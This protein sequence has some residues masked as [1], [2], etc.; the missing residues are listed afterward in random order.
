MLRFLVAAFLFA[1][2]AYAD[3][4][5]F[6]AVPLEAELGAKI[7]RAAEASLKDFP[8]LTADNLALSVI[9]VTKPDALVRADYHGDAPFYPASVIKLFFMVEAYREFATGSGEDVK[10]LKTLQSYKEKN[11]RIPQ[12]KLTPEI[13]RA[14]REMIQVSDNDAAAF[15]VDI[16]TDTCS[17]SELD[18]KALEDFLERRR[19]LNRS[20]ASLGYD[21]SAMQ[22]PWSFGPFGRDMQ[23]LGENKI[24]R[25]RATANS[26]ASLLLWIV[27]RRAISPQASDAMMS[28]LE[29][30]LSPP[31][32]T[33]NQ[34]KD[35]FGESLPPGAKLWSK[36]GETSEVRHDAAYLELPS[37]RK[38]IVVIFTRGL[39]DE[40]T[41]LPSIGK[42]LLQEIDGK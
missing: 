5:E 13:E 6:K 34:V 21:I 17:G 41:L 23:A 22:K 24:N 40:K 19:K 1:S 26:V 16:L 36:S 27:R 28:L 15:L 11:A 35:F 8:R 30:P 14:L 25:N 7:T 20:F 37:G 2:V 9:D 10:A 39:A 33:E 3:F 4:R 29:R 31:R 32:P 12:K 38:I 42:H 18:G